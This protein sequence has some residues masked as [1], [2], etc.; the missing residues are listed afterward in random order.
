MVILEKKYLVLLILLWLGA[1]VF[2]TLWPFN[3]L[4]KNEVTPMPGGGFH[5]ESPSIAYV[6]QVP[7]KIRTLNKFSIIM[8]VKS[9]I[10]LEDVDGIVFGYC[11]D[12]NNQNILMYQVHDIA[13]FTINVNGI[14]K[15]ISAEGIFENESTVWIEL[16]YNGSELTLLK[17]GIVRNAVTIGNLDFSQWNSSYPFVFAN[18]GDGMNPWSGTIFSYDVFDGVE[19]ISDRQQLD[20]LKSRVPPVI[21]LSGNPEQTGLYQTQGSISP[22][23]IIIPMWFIPPGKSL[24]VSLINFT[25]WAHIDYMDFFLNTL[26]FVPFGL[27]MRILLEKRTN[28]YYLSFFITIIAGV[29]LTISIE[30]LQIFLPV[31]Y[32]SMMDVLSNTLG[33]IAGATIVSISFVRKL[34]NL[35][36][37]T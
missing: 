24:L 31:R 21:S 23:S 14:S 35:K 33:T 28:R 5:F 34:L 11:I 32:T 20:T 27:L 37:Q 2:L 15:N 30:S 7:V 16:I 29:I 4:H 22:P 9:D 26:L 8:E 18:R 1:A 10:T 19:T 12:Y 25:E 3:F 13:G 6:G 36:R 17:N